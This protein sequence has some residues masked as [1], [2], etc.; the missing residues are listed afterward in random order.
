MRYEL[1]YLVGV[2]KELDLEKI[3]TEVDEIVQKGI[4]VES[5]LLKDSPRMKQPVFRKLSKNSIWI[6]EFCA[7][8]SAMQQNYR[9]WK[10]KK[11]AL[12]RKK[13]EAN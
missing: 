4:L 11:S 2:S 5:M 9:S 3:K 8:S 7:S 10:P 13:K 6:L 12:N 1:F